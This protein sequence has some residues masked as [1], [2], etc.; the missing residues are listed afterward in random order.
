MRG[1]EHNFDY[2]DKVLSEAPFNKGASVLTY[3]HQYPQLMP[4]HMEDIGHN[5]DKLYKHVK[6]WNWSTFR[7]SEKSIKTTSKGREYIKLGTKTLYLDEFEKY[8]KPTINDFNITLEYWYFNLE[9]KYESGKLFVRYLDSRS[10]RADI[11]DFKHMNKNQTNVE[12]GSY[13]FFDVTMT[14]TDFSENEFIELNFTK[15]WKN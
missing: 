9:Y 8:V 7:L 4:K 6:I 2:F 10:D 15:V 12:V 3:L 13:T 11:T 5:S 14:T 1:F